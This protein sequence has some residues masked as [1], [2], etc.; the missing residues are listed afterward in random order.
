M[1]LFGVGSLVNIGLK[2]F[3]FTKADLD[4]YTEPITLGYYLEP[5]EQM[6][7]IQKCEIAETDKEII[8]QWLVNYE[9]N[10]DIDVRIIERQEDA[11]DAI[12][13]I[14]VGFP[15]YL[16]HWGVITRDRK[17]REKNV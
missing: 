13:K 4:L 3:I 11:S 2:T 7:A 12:A 14:I 9:K 15:V 1:L 8:S 5:R 10:K 6:E 16:Y 17:R